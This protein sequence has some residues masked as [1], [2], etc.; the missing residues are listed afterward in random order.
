[1]DYRGTSDDRDDWWP[2]STIKLYAAVAA[3]ETLR[4]RGL[5]PATEVTFHY[6]EGAV[7]ARAS[8]LLRAAI[9]QSNN[10]AFDRLVELAGFDAAHPEFSTPRKGF[11]DTVS[12]RSYAHRLRYPDGNGSNRHS[13][14]IT[15][16]EGEQRV[17][18]PERPG[19]LEVQCADHG[20]CTTLREL[21]ET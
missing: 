21:A 7:T 13:P 17:E 6:A 5:S 19:S 18:L 4:A 12:Q 9:A 14:A 3:L 11:V 2:A 1:F 15:L 8:E 20:N 16:E 10:R